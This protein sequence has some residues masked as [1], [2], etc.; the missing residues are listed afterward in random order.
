MRGKP[1]GLKGMA[2]PK[3]QSQCWPHSPEDLG[4][5]WQD[6]AQPLHPNVHT[7][8]RSLEWIIST[9]QSK[10]PRSTCPL[11]AYFQLAHSWDAGVSQPWTPDLPAA[12][13][14]SWH[15]ELPPQAGTLLTRGATL[16]FPQE[17]KNEPL[18]PTAPS[19]FRNY[20]QL[21]GT[22]EA[23]SLLGGQ[24]SEAASANS[25]VQ[26]RR[27][28]TARRQRQVQDEAPPLCTSRAGS[29]VPGAR[30]HD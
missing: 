11:P 27:P 9:Q 15:P 5:R 30:A 10:C 17:D 21:T 22:Q 16:G 28:G 19:N 24:R 3:I 18:L 14:P 13:S 7:E 4:W 29:A 26:R 23:G 2:R 25:G 20:S 1:A 6:P 8:S 12:W